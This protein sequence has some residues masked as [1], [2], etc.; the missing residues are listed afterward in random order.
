EVV[1][2]TDSVGVQFWLNSPGPWRFGLAALHKTGVGGLEGIFR[3]VGESQDTDEFLL[4]VEAVFDRWVFRGE[5]RHFEATAPGPSFGAPVDIELDP[6]Y[7]QL[8]FFATEKVHLY[9]QYENQPSDTSSADY[10]RDIDWTGREEYSLGFNYFFSANVVLKA[11]YHIYEIGSPFYIPV[12]PP[13]GPPAFDFS[14]LEADDGEIFILSV[15][16]AF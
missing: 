10:V 15:S 9:L 6:F 11:E 7:L 2:A 12:F 13:D 1:R 14:L 4:S 5:M 8:G 16:T 3:E